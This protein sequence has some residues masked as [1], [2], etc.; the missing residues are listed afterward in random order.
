MNTISSS[1]LVRK[2]QLAAA[3]SVSPRTVDAWIAQR[4][5]PYLCVSPRLHLFNVEA[6]REA[7]AQRFEISARQNR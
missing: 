7:L 3:L 6:V 2:K 5:I 4:L 1:T